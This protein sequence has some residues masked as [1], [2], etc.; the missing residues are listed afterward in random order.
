MNARRALLAALLL[1]GATSGIARGDAIDD[2]APGYWCRVPDT[3]LQAVCPPES[4][5]YEWDFYCKRVVDAWSGATLDTARGRL[6]VWGGGHGDYKGNEVYAFD[7]ATLAWSRIW[8][9]TPEELIPSGQAAFEE[10]GDGNPGSRHTYSGLTYVPPPVDAML[11]M[12]GSLWQKGSFSK[13]TWSFSL[14]SRTWTRKVDGRPAEGFGDPSVYDPVTKHVFRRAYGR[15]VEYD[16]VADSYADRALLPNAPWAHNVAAALDPDARLMVM[17]GR[18][19]VDLYHLDTD[20]YELD[21]PLSGPS[22]GDLFGEESP[23]IDFDP[24]QREFVLWHGG[25]DVFTFDPVARAFSRHTGAGD[26]PGPVTTSGGVFGRFRYVPSRNV[27]VRVDKVDEDVF[28][29]RMA[30]GAGTPLEPVGDAGGGGGG[31]GTDTSGAAG[32]RRSGGC[33]SGAGVASLA[34]VLLAS[35]RYVRR[36]RSR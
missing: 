15:M 21:V 34:L 4:A 24:V 18:G 14:A 12:G 1:A 9:P 2:L 29:F 32:P 7:F 8:G 19:R 16:P 22:V 5:S 6:L 27:F 25:L 23:G 30:P 11:S 33:G 26:D 31:G 28:V 17:V 20:Q 35:L 13:A 3:K 10:Y 36:R